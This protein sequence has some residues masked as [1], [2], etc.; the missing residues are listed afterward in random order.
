VGNGWVLKKSKTH[1]ERVGH[2]LFLVRVNLEHAA[3]VAQYLRHLQSGAAA[4]QVGERPGAYIG[5]GRMPILGRGCLTKMGPASR[6]MPSVQS[7]RSGNAQRQDA[8]VTARARD[9]RAE[10]IGPTAKGSKAPGMD[11]R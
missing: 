6:I 2:L 10:S 1:H 3:P 7:A 5:E 8:G 4:W 9:G 11:V